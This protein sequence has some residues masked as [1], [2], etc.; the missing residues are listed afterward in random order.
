MESNGSVFRRI[1]VPLDGS[2]FAEQALPYA[3]AAAP[4]AEFVL[5][6]VTPVPEA[7]RNELGQVV[8]SVDEVAPRLE[9]AARNGLRRVE[10]AWLNRCE[11]VRL[12]VASG[13]PAEEILR[14]AETAACDLIVIASHGRGA[15]GRLLFGSV[16]DRVA[17]NSPIPVLIIRPVDT[18]IEV[19][20]VEL[21]RLIVPLDGSALAAQALPVAAALAKQDAL[22]LV[23]LRAIDLQHMC[24]PIPATSSFLKRSSTTWRTNRRLIS[25][26]APPRSAPRASPSRRRSGAGRRSTRSPERRAKATWS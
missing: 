3:L 25:T 12:E 19:T 1:L 20:R 26:H 16:A 18:A 2:F 7:E 10:G 23:L 13:D 14:L 17:H 15:G 8:A 11:H 9:A 22:P 4:N 6:A 24:R 5:L 21:R